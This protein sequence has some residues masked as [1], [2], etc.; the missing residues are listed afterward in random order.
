MSK[1]ISTPGLERVARFVAYFVRE[2]AA[3]PRSR[4]YPEQR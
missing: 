2:A 1:A 3:A 4:F